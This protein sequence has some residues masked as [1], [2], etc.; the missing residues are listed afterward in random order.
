LSPRRARR[1]KLAPTPERPLRS[2]LNSIDIDMNMQKPKLGRPRL[3]PRAYG[4]SEPAAEVVGDRPLGTGAENLHGEN[5]S[6]AESPPWA[7]SVSSDHPMTETIKSLTKLLFERIQEGK[8][9]FGTRL[10]SERDLAEELKVSRNTVRHALDVLEEHKVVQ[11]RPGSGSFVIYRRK[12]K[13]SSLPGAVF[14]F[15]E[16][17]EITSPLELNVVR[18]IV[19]PEMIRLA[20]INMTNRDLMKLRDVLDKLESV[21]TDSRAFLRWD[22]AF[23]LQIAEGGH[24]PLLIANY[25]LISYVRHHA[26]WASHKRERISPGRI[27]EYNREHR[28]IYEALEARDIESA[29][30]FVKIHLTELQRDLLRDT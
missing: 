8:Y 30:E 29:V 18:S 25:K 16:I 27:L 23:H 21:T 22:E 2:G 26:H 14:D 1:V 12:A 6:D 3:N 5:P 11:R 15:H 13:K 28:S 19:E 7:D 20:V 24:N 4:S 10:P 17:A 9:A